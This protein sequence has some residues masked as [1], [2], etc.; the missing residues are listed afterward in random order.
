MVKTEREIK[1]IIERYK[2]ELKKLGI[3]PQRVILYGSYAGGHPQEDSDID[4]I[5][6]SEDFKDMNLRERLEALGLAAG[7]VFEPIEA[8]GYTEEEVKDTKGTFLEEILPAS[9]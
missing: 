8:I 2:E 1:A 5:V 3:R 4:L 9:H 6:I 7:R